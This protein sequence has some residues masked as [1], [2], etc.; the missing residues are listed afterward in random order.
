MA[1]KTKKK[2]GRIVVK[3]FIFENGQKKRKEKYFGR[4]KTA[5]ALADS[6]KAEIEA[7][8]YAKKSI[9]TLTFDR[10]KPGQIYF[11]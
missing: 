1:S 7:R 8:D 10:G 11:S 9:S 6:F 4:G 2:D 3:Y 5:D